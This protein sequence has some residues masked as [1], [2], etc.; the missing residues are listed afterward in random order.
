M[1]KM[2]IM[3]SSLTYPLPNGVTASLNTAVDGLLANGHE[4]MIVAPDY[5]IKKTRPEHY[6]V[7]SSLILHKVAKNILGKEERVF[8]MNSKKKIEELAEKFNP[9]IYWLHSVTWAANAFEQQMIKSKKKKVL[10]Y[11]TLVEEYGRLYAGDMGAFI[12]RKRTESLG[13]KVDAIMTPSDMMRKKLVEYGVKKPINI[14][15]TGIDAPQKSFTKKEIKEKFNIPDKMKILLYL[16]RMSKE[17]NLDV[18]L[19]MIKELKEKN[20]N[21]ILLFVGPGDI[22][23]VNEDAKKMNVSDRV[24]CTGSLKR[25]DA[26]RV[27]GAC[28][29][30]VFSSQTETQGLVIGEAMLARTPVVALVS[31][32][33]KEVYPEG[34]A[35]VVK[36]E[37]D[38]AHAVI[39]ILENGKERERMI[40]EAENFVLQNFSKKSMI[41]KQIKVFKEV[42]KN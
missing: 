27:Y 33:Q 26:Q 20:Y 17:K 34:K 19:D 1:E 7:P 11:H 13:N 14:I 9:D 31:P 10:F 22:D 35:V 37:K 42:L 2:K 24:I 12:M 3:V 40:E 15:P 41:E 16:G 30:F 6:T 38:F 5:K 29:A 4:V 21:A 23:E 28:D 39:D 36:K 18:L 32:I 8:R 25:E